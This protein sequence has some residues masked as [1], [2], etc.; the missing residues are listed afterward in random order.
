MEIVDAGSRGWQGEGKGVIQSCPL[1]PSTS[2]PGSDLLFKLSFWFRADLYIYEE[3]MLLLS[4]TRA[5]SLLFRMGCFGSL[6]RGVWSWGATQKASANPLIWGRLEMRTAIS[7]QTRLWQPSFGLCFPSPRSTVTFQVLSQGMW[8]PPTHTM[9][10]SMVRST[11]RSECTLKFRAIPP[12]SGLS[13]DIHVSLL[14]AQLSCALQTFHAWCCNQQ[15]P[16]QILQSHQGGCSSAC[17]NWRAIQSAWESD[18]PQ[19][20]CVNITPKHS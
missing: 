17:I 15:L 8:K 1:I 16:K 2:S 7:H 10:I 12:T 6:I 5:I 9:H 4:L 11:L 19:Q 3:R 14:L 13:G 20:S 18:F